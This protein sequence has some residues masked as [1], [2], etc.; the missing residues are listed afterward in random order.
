MKKVLIAV[1]SLFAAMTLSCTVDLDSVN[2]R[3][4]D[5]EDR[6]EILEELCERLN[7]NISSLQTIISALEN[8]DY[9]TSVTPIVQGGDTIGYMVEFSKSGPIMIY[10]GRDGADGQDGEDG[11][12]GADGQDGEDGSDGVDGHTP[13]IGVRQDVDG[14]Y[15][16][17]LDGEWLLDEN[18][19]KVPV[20]GSDGADGQDG[21]DG[22]DGVTPQL[23]IEDE[24]WWVSY[25]GGLNWTKLGK[26]VGEDGKDGQD[27]QDG[28]SMF[29]DIDYVSNDDYVIFTLA[30]G[31]VIK[32][33]KF[34]ELTIT[35]DRTADIVCLPGGSVKVYYTLQGG[36]ESTVVESVGDGG[37]RSEIF[38]ESV[39]SGYIEVTAPAPMTDGKVL[40]FVSGNGQV[41]MKSLTFIAGVLAVESDYY[42]VEAVETVLTVTVSTNV[43]YSVQIPESA[44][45]WLSCAET[46]STVRT[47]IVEFFVQDNPVGSPKREA[48]V[49]LVGADGDVLQTI[50]IA[51]KAKEGFVQFAD[52][53]FKGYMVENFDTDGDGEISFS[54]AA[55]VTEIDYVSYPDKIASLGGIEYCT[56][57]KKLSCGFYSGKHDVKE[58]NLSNHP[59]L[60]YLVC[61][62]VGLTSLDVSGCPNLKYLHC[63]ENELKSESFHVTGCPEL[64]FLACPI[65]GITWLDLEGCVSLKELWCGRN[66]IS[67][68][69]NIEDCKELETINCR[70]ITVMP[71]SGVYEPFTGLD[72]L[73]DLDM[74]ECRLYGSIT[75]PASLQRLQCSNLLGGIGDIDLSACVDL[76]YLDCSGSGLNLDLSNNTGLKYL[77]CSGC[78]LYDLDLSNNR[79]LYFLDCSGNYLSTL[80]I[81][82]TSIGKGVDSNYYEYPLDCSDMFTLNRLYIDAGVEIC[83]VTYNRSEEYIGPN[84]TIERV[85]SR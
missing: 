38:T 53:N 4:D 7:T 34:Q 80:D 23:K 10:H 19:D 21:V 51:Q 8:N 82:E 75:L 3:L 74:S 44:Q 28:E 36:D 37:W 62:G 43:D 25:D 33:P 14:V 70:G 32:F 27:G 26:A 54:E 24:Y 30:D 15:Y 40:V 6:V 18:G 16:W 47:D 41:I 13:Q 67:N 46:R 72:K 63:S 22:K 69:A 55:A 73:K 65:N 66:P 77:D 59:S 11:S 68:I 52:E 29:S 1:A 64:E 39:S 60:E 31:F 50:T 45:T 61:S 79:N 78:A 57:L 83:G 17:T 2:D 5:L 48:V 76:E 81:S 58:L 56:S 35:F 20:Q 71:W 49:S 9:I 12:D 85:Y 84:T 42:E